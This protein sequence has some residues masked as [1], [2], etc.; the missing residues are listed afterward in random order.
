M[1]KES[2]EQAWIRR[3]KATASMGDFDQ[4]HAFSIKD[5]TMLGKPYEEGDDEWH[6]EFK[7]GGIEWL[8][9]AMLSMGEGGYPNLATRK[10][11]A[12]DEISMTAD[13]MDLIDAYNG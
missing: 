2:K 7:V 6:Q 5:I 1:S 11:A 13:E 8:S 3:I 10:Q 4:A 9:A 12:L